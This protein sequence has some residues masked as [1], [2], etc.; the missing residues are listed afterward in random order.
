MNSC[1][2][3][4]HNSQRLSDDVIGVVSRARQA[5]RYSVA[6]LNANTNANAN[7]NP[8]QSSYTPQTILPS[9]SGLISPMDRKRVRDEPTMPAETQLKR[10]HYKQH[11]DVIKDV[12]SE[13][14]RLREL[15]RLRQIR[16]RKKK[17]EYANTLD[18]ENKQL[19]EEI[20]TLEQRRRS[21][22]AAV[23]AKENVWSVAAEYFR[24]FRYG[25]QTA[26]ASSTS[27]QPS[28]QQD[29]L[30]NCM[31]A[32]VVFNA[33]RGPEAMAKSWKCLSLWFQAVEFELEGLQKGVDGSL[34]AATITSV[35]ITDRTLRN[36]F[37]HLPS[38]SALRAKL[39]DQRLVMRGSMRF[40]W[41]PAFGRVCCLVA[42]S[43]MLA[44]MLRLLGGWDDVSKVFE[45]ALISPDFQWRANA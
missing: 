37:P 2:L 12:I 34:E 32:D 17:A 7:A 44:P 5:E 22:A 24:L 10:R 20:D 6:D 14:D 35:T 16:Y 11:E 29:F 36:V 1:V 43:N 27:T 3:R 38:D 40:E 4:P 18:A 45:R 15:R 31:T 42:Q 19:Q 25:F 8:M 41:D 21:F 26:A 33:G 30:R 23:P 28:M 9:T 39:L 13:Q